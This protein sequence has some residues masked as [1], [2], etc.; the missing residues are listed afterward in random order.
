MASYYNALGIALAETGKNSTVFYGSATTGKALAGTDANDAF[1]GFAYVASY[2]GGTGDDSYYT[3]N[4]YDTVIEKAG[5][6]IDTVYAEQNFKL[7]AN[8]ENL[9]LTTQNAWYGLGNAMDN[10]M[11]AKVAG[12]TLDGGA[13]ND[14]L[15]SLAANTTFIVAKGNG[16]DAIYGFD[17]TDKI[18]LDNYGI[19]SFATIKSLGSQVGTDTVLK[20]TNGEQLVLRDT[21]LA[22]LT[23]DNFM[24][25]HDTSTLV[26]TFADDFDALSLYSKGGTWRTE[27][28]WGGAGTLGSRTLNGEAEIYMDA[29]YAGTGKAALGINPF[30][31]DKGILSITAAPTPEAAK[32]HL[33]NAAY[34]S[35]LLTTKF[36]FAQEYG[37]FEMSAKLP[38]GQGIWPAF[39][40]LPTDNSWPPELDVFETLGRDVDTVFLTSHGVDANGKHTQ[41]QSM[42][43]LDYTQWHTYGADWGPDKITY[44]IDGQ[45]VATQATP[46][47]MKGKNMYMLIDLAVGGGGWA[48][49][50]DATTGTQQMQVDFV[51]AYATAN[52]ISTTVNGVTTA[53]VQPVAAPPVVT[54]PVVVVP[55]PAPPVTVPEA[56]Q[57]TGTATADKLIATANNTEMWG[58]TGDDTLRAGSFSARMHGGLGNDTYYVIAVDQLVFE[59]AGEGNDVVRS[60]ISFTLAANIETLLLD[61]GDNINGTGN[62]LGNRIIGN[63]GNNVI[64]GGAGN[65]FLDGGTAGIDTIAGGK[66]DD[67]YY[68]NHAG[69]TLIEKAGE[70]NDVVNSTIT[71]TLG[72]NFETLLLGGTDNINGTGNDLGNRITGNSGNNA[73]TGGAGNDFLDGGTAGFDVLAG[74]M[75]TDTYYVNHVGTVLIENP[76]E[77]NDV[78]NSTITWTLGSNFETL[79]L[80]GTDNINGT[81][82]DLGNRITGNTGN[83]VITG[84]AGNDFL[85]GGTAGTDTIA[86]GKGDDTYYVNHAG[87]TL[88]ENQ[89]EGNDVVNST[90]SWTLGANFETLVLSGTA[91]INGTGNALA[92]RI[93][94]NGGDNILNGGAG[95]D[96]LTGGGG[97][98]TFVFDRG[99]GKDVVT[100]FVAKDDYLQFTGYSRAQFHIVQQGANAVIDFGGTDT[101]TLLNTQANDPTLLGHL[102]F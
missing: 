58:Y 60:T 12:Q 38:T 22:S 55:D 42:V 57:L 79:L 24:L 6:G 87:T 49:A 98:D 17:A 13:G 65:D 78:V 8:V 5:E 76:G 51:R 9:T 33:G 27:Y 54:P 72:A 81:G 61:G 93:V 37:Y 91:N 71:W 2:A 29:D 19:T 102:L 48:G 15:V 83:N 31:I 45:A 62:D 59:N 43:N 52:T 64:T 35:G 66:G 34:T 18:R 67:T 30:G 23:A 14:V 94:G 25:A 1:R 85:D 32:P 10:I 101:I 99:F 41:S 70:G 84:G 74:G 95:N 90:I 36:T 46:D 3:N 75:G 53:Y 69:T 44:Y 16:S 11:T 26:S 89:G 40:L 82:N 47:S 86:G 88:I 56:R 96:T 68:V 21:K 80:G 97:K 100:D 28:G 50:Y 20:F 63:T 77:G 92:N 7:G 39:W 4:K 73:I